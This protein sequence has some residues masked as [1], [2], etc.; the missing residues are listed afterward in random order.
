MRAEPLDVD[1]LVVEIEFL[2]QGGGK[3]Q[4]HADRIDSGDFRDMPVHKPRKIEQNGEIK[5]D[6][7]LNVRSLNLDS[8]RRAIRQPR[9]MHLRD[10]RASHRFRRRTS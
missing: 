3:F 7:F 8:Y 4:H 1:C 10:R 2:A 6:H 5:L 9:G